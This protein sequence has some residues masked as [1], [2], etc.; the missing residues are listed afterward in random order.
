[1]SL[2]HVG[3]ADLFEEID[4]DPALLQD[5]DAM[6]RGRAVLT[7]LRN[8]AETGPVVVA[9]DDAQWLDSASARAVR[10]AVRRFEA[11]PVGVLATTRV[12]ADAGDALAA[13]AAFAPAAY[14]LLE[15]GPL[16]LG[17]LRRVLAGTVPSISR[18]LL[19][20][21]Y[22]ALKE[23]V[24]VEEI[25]RRE[26]DAV[27]RALYWWRQHPNIEILGNPDLDR[28][29]IVSLGIRHPRG[30]LHSHFL[31]AVLSDLFGIQVRSGCVCAGPYVHRLTPIDAP[32]SERMHAEACAGHLG[33]KLSYLRL[34]F[35]YFWS[36][37]V[38]NY[39]IAAVQLLA[40]HGWKL[41][42]L[43]RFDPET[44]I[45]RHAQAPP[46]PSVSLRGLSF[47]AGGSG[48]SR[49]RRT[50]PE[51]ALARHLAEARSV[52]GQ[53]EAEPP[54]E[55][56][57]DPALTPEFERIRWFPLPAEAID[58]LESGRARDGAVSAQAAG[59]ELTLAR[60]T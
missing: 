20:R 34:S 57:S 6:A 7:A 14:E 25:R 45:W 24:G 42:P 5:D 33:A 48:L 53:I 2:A 56:L 23:Q 54:R 21:I 52:I 40:T 30:L 41:L 22:F 32:W 59:I 37:A 10:Y 11:E 38:L 43:Y 18:P 13:S 28:L 16:T 29:A 12:G 50:E 17:P 31:A 35:N 55:A 47:A 15:L 60:A 39:V 46:E 19:R 36:D 26:Q 44:G 58:D 1:M 51:S 27:R 8:L 3:L 9:I 49:R 4:V